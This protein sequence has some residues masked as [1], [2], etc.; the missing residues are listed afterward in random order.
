VAR[1][2]LQQLQFL[3]AAENLLITAAWS[4]SMVGKVKFDP[5]DED[6]KT[7]YAR[8]LKERPEFAK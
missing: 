3:L 6:V 1:A 2:D 5:N 8:F 4:I 7:E